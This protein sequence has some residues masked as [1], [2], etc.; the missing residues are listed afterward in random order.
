M[1]LFAGLGGSIKDDSAAIDH[2]KS[3]AGGLIG[4]GSDG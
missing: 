3:A 4:G 2:A 1:A